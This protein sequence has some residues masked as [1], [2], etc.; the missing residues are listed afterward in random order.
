MISKQI[1]QFKCVV[2]V[3]DQDFGTFC[4]QR[5][6]EEKKRFGEQSGATKPLVEGDMHA[7]VEVEMMVGVVAWASWAAFAMWKGDGWL[8]GLQSLLGWLW[9]HWIV[10]LLGGGGGRD[11]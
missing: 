10:L 1:I 8:A 7:L 5:D 9:W 3:C 11:A 6:L 4:R 2:N